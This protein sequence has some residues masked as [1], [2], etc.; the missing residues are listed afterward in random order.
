MLISEWLYQQTNELKL[1]LSLIVVKKKAAN[2]KIKRK[3]LK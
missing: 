1:V 2:L 3:K